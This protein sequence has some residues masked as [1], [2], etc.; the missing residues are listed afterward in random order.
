VTTPAVG[1]DATRSPGFYSKR[2]CPKCGVPVNPIEL[3]RVGAVT[4]DSEVLLMVNHGCGTTL[5]VVL[6]PHADD[7]RARFASERPVS[8]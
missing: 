2:C 3:P 8:L 4:Y 6:V 5:A 1:S 7:V